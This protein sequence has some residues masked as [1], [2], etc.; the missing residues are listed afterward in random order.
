[1]APT[2]AVIACGETK[3]A[4]PGPALRFD[5]LSVTDSPS[6]ADPKGGMMMVMMLGSEDCLQVACFRIHIE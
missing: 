2:D 4:G 6:S 3:N 1:M 5:V